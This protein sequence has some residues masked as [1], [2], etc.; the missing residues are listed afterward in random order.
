MTKYAE[1]MGVLLMV[2]Q[3]ESFI[4]NGYRPPSGSFT[5]FIEDVGDLLAKY[6][7]KNDTCF[8]LGDFNIPCNKTASRK[9]NWNQR[10][11]KLDWRTRFLSLLQNRA[12]FLVWS[13]RIKRTIFGVEL[14]KALSQIITVSFF[15][16]PLRSTSTR[17]RKQTFS[18]GQK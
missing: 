14:I 4:L 9:K 11:K 3:T 1:M 2:N 5:P 12:T 15:P 7:A 6:C 16:S 13:L 8:V 17:K 10:S 18:N